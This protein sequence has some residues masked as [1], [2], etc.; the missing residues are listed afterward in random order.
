M[1]GK[2]VLVVAPHADDEVLGCGGT[3][4]RH[5]AHGDHVHVL[6]MTTGVKELFSAEYMNRLHDEMYVAHQVLGVESTKVLDFP[7]P[8]LDTISGST[9][10]D[11]ILEVLTMLNP[12]TIYFPHRGDLHTDHQKVHAAL[13]VAA[14][15]IG[16]QFAKKLLTYETL[17]ETDWAPP[18]ADHAFLPNVYVDITEYLD[19]KLKAMKCYQSQLKSPPHT[20]SLESLAALARIRGG[21]VN[22][23]AAEAF[24]L[25]REIQGF[26]RL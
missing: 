8:H 2:Q 1:T 24:M 4:A 20:R 5:V 11:A 10:A 26:T 3:I 7:A 6:V 21:T 23:E 12:E 9:L 13:L 14:R 25:I 15:P 17:S 18:S 22:F 19:R 16:L